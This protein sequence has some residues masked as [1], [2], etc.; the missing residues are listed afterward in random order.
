MDFK[1]YS[2]LFHYGV[3]G[4]HWGVRRYQNQDGSLTLEGKKRNR[5]RRQ[6]INANSSSKDV[7]D[8]IKSMN[9]DDRN[10][11]LAGSDHYLNLEEGAAVA[12]RV[13]KKMGDK[14]I[15]FFDILEDGDDTF[16]LALGTRGGKKY[17][18]KGYGSQVT[19]EAMNWLE[20]NKHKVSQKKIVWGVR[21][22]NTASIKLAEKYGFELEPGSEK[23]GW[24]NYV[25][26]IKK[27]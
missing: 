19:K 8:I 24:V 12:K 27:R 14:P 1:R 13:I 11:V 2:E 9:K 5:Y 15:A 26:K 17:R 22:D 3:K 20:K 16:Q 25:K 6:A 23:D 10:K 7:N 4:M 21:K 18:G